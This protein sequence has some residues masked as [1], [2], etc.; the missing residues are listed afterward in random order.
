MTEKNKVK[1][2]GTTHNTKKKWPR[3]LDKPTFT[4]PTPRLE[5]IYPKF[6]SAQYA[7]S[8]VETKYKLEKYTVVLYKQNSADS[9]KNMKYMRSPD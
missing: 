2:K 1:S 6:G 4:P 5:R 8:F 7:D 9:G 3:K